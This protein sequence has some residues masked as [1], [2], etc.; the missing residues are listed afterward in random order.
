MKNVYEIKKEKSLNYILPKEEM[1]SELK[2]DIF[3]SIIVVI[4]IY[5]YD[6]IDMYLRYIENIPDDIFVLI[7]VSEEKTKEHIIACWKNKISK[8]KI[9]VKPN[10]GR[11][12]SSL[13]VAAKEEI[14]KYK[15]VCFLHDK[16]EKNIEK[17]KDVEHW[18]YCLW[19]NT[20]GSNLFIKNIIYTFEK[21]NHL[22][23]LVP[24]SPIT[25][26]LEYGYVNPWGNDFELTSQ[27]VNE[28]KLNC[29]LKKTF[30]PIVLGTVFWAKT[31]ALKKLFE[32]NW[33]YDDFEPEPLSDDGTL[34]H[35]IERILPYVAQDAGYESGWVMTDR[36]AS[37]QW[38]YYIDVLRNF[39]DF[40]ENTYDIIHISKSRRLFHIVKELPLFCSYYQKVYIYGAG[41]IGKRCFGIMVN[42]NIPLESFLVSE[43]T[44]NIH[45]T[46]YGMLIQSVEEIILDETCGIIIAVRKDLVEEIQN[47]LLLKGVLKKDIY[48]FG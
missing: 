30:P 45:N 48:V 39:F 40:F 14:L 26:N 9:I 6:R 32:V 42:L 5:Y 11:D 4:H 25:E 10:R 37:E 24:P 21:N 7:T 19:E 22:G 20:I 43:L 33:K 31:D 35:A 44:N 23:L 15:Y 36:Y 12:I 18:N 27:L 29:N 28:M 16:R 46:F 3:Q 2:E 13:L 8:Y 17:K 41:E 47:K 38:E 1:L 34:S